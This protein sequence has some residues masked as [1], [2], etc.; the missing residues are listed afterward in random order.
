M[1]SVGQLRPASP[2]IRLGSQNRDFVEKKTQSFDGTQPRC[3][4]RQTAGNEDGHTNKDCPEYIQPQ[5]GQLGCQQRLA[6]VAQDCSNGG[7]VQRAAPA[8]QHPNDDFNGIDR[9]EFTRVDDSHLR[10]LQ[11][12]SDAR[13][14][15]RKHKE[16][17][18]V[19]LHP[20]AK[21]SRPA[22]RITDRTDHP[23]GS[24]PN[25]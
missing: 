1:A 5:L 22:L 3:Q 24:R 8:D 12:P 2:A 17:Q 18:L 20:I 21:K 25:D 6:I 19:G 16:P 14:A 4:T 11:G 15:R 7:A 10:H 23:A 13:Q 9:L